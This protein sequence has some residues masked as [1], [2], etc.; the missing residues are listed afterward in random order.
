[1]A[2]LILLLG[3][4][5]TW[6]EGTPGTL[7]AAGAMFAAAS[8]SFHLFVPLA[9]RCAWC[10]ISSSGNRVQALLGEGGRLQVWI[11]TAKEH[12]AAGSQESGATQYLSRFRLENV[13]MFYKTYE[14][15][16][17]IPMHLH[18]HSIFKSSLIMGRK[19]YV[20]IFFER[21]G[22]GLANCTFQLF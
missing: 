5:S 2:D 10:L 7:L 9:A 18:L 14:R 21:Q 12:I 20:F 19:E 13:Q 4:P 16:K 8:F 22:W 3:A 1:M 17:G 6:A 11:W 15:D